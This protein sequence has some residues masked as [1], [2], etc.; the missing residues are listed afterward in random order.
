ME[1]PAVILLSMPLNPGSV[2]PIQHA[3]A[4]IR[5]TPRAPHPQ[6]SRNHG[7]KK[8]RLAARRTGPSWMSIWVYKRA[9]GPARA[10]G[11]QTANWP[12]AISELPHS[13]RLGGNIGIPF[14]SKRAPP[15]SRFRHRLAGV[16]TTPRSPLVGVI[17][18]RSYPSDPTPEPRKVASRDRAFLRNL[19]LTPR[20]FISSFISS[21]RKIINYQN[22]KLLWTRNTRYLP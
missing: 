6:L 2:A 4:E 17:L 9:W 11:R 7:E 10:S 15:I 14:T 13:R 19:A 1:P 21:G 3:E 20:N 8:L 18:N 22:T 5:A 16:P 12:T